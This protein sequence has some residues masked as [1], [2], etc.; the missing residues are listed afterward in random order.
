MMNLFQHQYLSAAIIVGCSTLSFMTACHFYRHYN[1]LLNRLKIETYNSD[2]LNTLL[3]RQDLDSVNLRIEYDKISKQVKLLKKMIDDKRI[4][5]DEMNSL[6]RD[7]DQIY[8]DEQQIR[9]LCNKMTQCLAMKC[10]EK[11]TNLLSQG[12]INNGIE[13]YRCL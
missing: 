11:I 2:K 5:I 4:R 7:Y 6:V 10:K 13:T 1:L 9:A 8:Q 3:S 12:N